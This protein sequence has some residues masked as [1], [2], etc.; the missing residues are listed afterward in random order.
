M[1]IKEPETP[2]TARVRCFLVEDCARGS[3]LGTS[4]MTGCIDTAK[5]L[6][7]EHLVL[8]TTNLSGSA[9]RLY[10]KFGFRLESKTEHQEWGIRH[11][12]ETW[13]MEL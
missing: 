11:I 7:Y 12:G 6:G 5:E 1:L 4:L 9:R 3:G 10:A 8:S 13:R 2:S